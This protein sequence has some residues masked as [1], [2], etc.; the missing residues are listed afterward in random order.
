MIVEQARIHYEAVGR[1]GFT[2]APIAAAAGCST[3]TVFRYFT[4]DG[5]LALVEHAVLRDLLERALKRETLGA[6]D[7]LIQMALDQMESDLSAHMKEP[8]DG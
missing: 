3:A 7:R 8:K 2:V 5:L 6:K 4:R 1:V